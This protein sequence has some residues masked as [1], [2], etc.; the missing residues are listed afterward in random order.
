[1][2]IIR[3]QKGVGREVFCPKLKNAEVF[4][5]NV[6]AIKTVMFSTHLNVHDH[7]I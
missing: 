7:C 1:M 5:D 4:D 2:G 3:A 6:Y